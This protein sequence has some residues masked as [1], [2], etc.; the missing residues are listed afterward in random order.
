LVGRQAKDV[1]AALRQHFDEALQL[2]LEEGF[3]D[4]RF[5]EAKFCCE[6]VL[7]KSG[8]ETQ[9]PIDDPGAQFLADK[10]G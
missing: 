9:S 10:F 1:G 2:E 8:P 7:R 6:C 5:R 4:R 3:T